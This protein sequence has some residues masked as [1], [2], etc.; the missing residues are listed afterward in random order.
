[1]PQP[2]GSAKDDTILLLTDVFM[3]R[4]ACG[5]TVT[6][7]APAPRASVSD[8]VEQVEDRALSRTDPVLPEG[9]EWQYEVKWDGYRMQALKE[10]GTVRLLSRNGADYTRRF[11]SVAHAVARL[12]P[13]TLH[14][15]AQRQGRRGER[16]DREVQGEPRDRSDQREPV[17]SCRSPSEIAGSAMHNYIATSRRGRFSQPTISLCGWLHGA[18][19]KHPP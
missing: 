14:L 12:K 10:R 9:P 17:E 16:Q 19:F 4:R 3:G 1:M 18:L 13:R 15:D 2:V 6:S 7:T 11:A 5:S 8:L